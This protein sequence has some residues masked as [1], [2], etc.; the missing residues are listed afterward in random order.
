MKLFSAPFRQV[1]RRLARTPVF[2]AVALVTI[3]VAIGAN[4]AIFS[5][6]NG[7]LLKPLNYQEPDRLVGVWE[8]APGIGLKDVNASPATYLTFREEGRAFT[9]IGMWSDDSVSVTG[10]AEPQQVDAVDITDG[11]LPVLGVHP[12]LGHSFSRLEDSPAGPETVML[13]FGYWQRHF[14]GDRSAIG[15]RLLIDGKAHEIVGIL[16]ADFRF[17]DR[18]PE[19]LLPMRLNRKDV[20]IGNFSYQ[21]LARLKP[22]VTISQATADIARMLPILMRKFP[23][24]PGMSLQMFLNARMAP[25]LRP[26]KQD[27]VGDIGSVLWILLLTVGIV[28]LIACANVANLLL[29][30][31]EGRQ[32]E[33]AIC[34]ALGA[35]WSRIARQ[36]LSESVLLGLSGGVLGLGLA[37]AALRLLVRLAPANL[38]R[39]NEISLAPP[40]LL[41]TLLVSLFAGVLFGIL[42]V[43]KYAGRQLGTTLRE[44]GRSL[45]EGRER[46][47][48]RNLLVIAQV[49]LCLVLLISS[50]LMI[51]TLF[52]LKRVQPGFTHP[53]ETLTFRISVPEG[54][55]KEPDRVIHLYQD[56]GQKMAALPG[57]RS[58]GLSNSI[59]MDGSTEHDPIFVEDHPFA[60]GK[61]PP[62][63]L[64]HFISPNYFHTMGSPL[65][66]GRDVNWED[67]FGKRPSVLVTENLAREYWGSPNAALGKRIRESP[68]AFWKQIVGVVGNV[69]DDG[70]NKPA[71]AI[72]YWPLLQQEFWGFKDNVT[73]TVTFAVSSPRTGSANFSNEVRQAVW[74][75]NRDLPIAEV[76]TVADIYNKSLSRVSFTLVML[77]LAGC[78]ALLLGVVGIYGVVSYSVAQRTR[79]IG[80]RMALGAPHSNVR[81]L[82]VRHA[83]LLTGIGLLVGLVAAVAESSLMSSLLFDVKPLDPLTYLAVAIFLAAAALV[84]SYLP[85]R[86]A[87]MIDP[88]EALRAE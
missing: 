44:G 45:S 88:V 67:E 63:R 11:V 76:R 57:V 61:I 85:A 78:M 23:P 70:A 86:K 72:V 19:L 73:R 42:P 28:L 81:Q 24:A 68:K 54:L 83:L 9:D 16:P 56:I 4:T 75:V 69:H 64:Y 43:F 39:L 58:V 22:G 79:E 46:H 3:A 82:F 59:T 40:V 65:L 77:A 41:F 74:S 55:I 1:L 18:Q 31:A 21:A 48:A 25:N 35:G 32:Q 20:F 84:A 15:R 36:L 33:L 71:P 8:T 66:A 10:L 87:T 49:A 17:M 34:A 26:L 29:V 62:L 13:T 30:R 50:G 6:V 47:R 12:I 5:V 27:V 14:G 53:A 52:A 80:I 2:T 51:R 38:P 37:W 60:E 7:V